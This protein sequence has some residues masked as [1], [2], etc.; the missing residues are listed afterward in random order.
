LEAE[1]IMQA[2][3][4]VIGFVVILFWL[5][6]SPTQSQAR[7]PKRDAVK[8]ITPPTTLPVNQAK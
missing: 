6:P 3:A 4:F 5:A 2:R 8:L 7:T 1:N